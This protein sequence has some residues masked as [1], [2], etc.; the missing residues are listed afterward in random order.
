MLVLV[1]LLVEETR[2][3]DGLNPRRRNAGSHEFREESLL[4][5]GQNS[6]VWQGSNPKTD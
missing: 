3:N 5:R 2:E 1:E 4:P 6:D